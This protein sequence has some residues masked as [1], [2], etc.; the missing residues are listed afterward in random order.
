MSPYLQGSAGLMYNNLNKTVRFGPQASYGTTSAPQPGLRVGFGMQ[1]DGLG[2]G[3]ILRNLGLEGDV[4]YDFKT[5]MP[6]A[7]VKLNFEEGGVKEK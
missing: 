1:K 7:G 5:G 2:R 6:T 3:K 4:S